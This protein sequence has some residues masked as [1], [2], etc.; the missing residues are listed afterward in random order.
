M[1]ELSTTEYAVLGILAEGPSHGFAISKQLEPDGDLGR[2]LTV[3][4]PLVYR[5]LDRLVNSGLAK[6][7]HTEKSGSGPNRL[8]HRATRDGQRELYRWLDS[9][10]DHVR[11][12]RIVF[13]L[14]VAL[15]LRARKS[16]RQLIGA[17]RQSLEPTLAALDDP[18]T[19]DH[20]EI[21]RRHNARAAASYLEELAGLYG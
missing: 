9:P 11:E 1:V 10:V 8:I 13:L 16:P 18:G 20:V 6:P 5:A 17:Q 12:I 14:K 4:R 3:R 15:L 21:W 7:A 2:I 19:D